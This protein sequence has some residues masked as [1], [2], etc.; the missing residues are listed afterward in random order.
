MKIKEKA[1][2][3]KVLGCFFGLVV[4]S[5]NAGARG[6]KKEEGRYFGGGHI[7]ARSATHAPA[8][9]PKLAAQASSSKIRRSQIFYARNSVCFAHA[10]DA[11]AQ[12]TMWRFGDET[13]ELKGRRDPLL[14]SVG[15]R[16]L[17]KKRPARRGAPSRGG[18]RWWG[19]VD[20]AVARSSEACAWRGGLGAG[21]HAGR[22]R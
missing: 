17:K 19:A 7:R 15:G 1:V 16:I 13:A 10:G 12:K 14:P 4:C 9:G 8:A 6:V 21:M 18:A 20:S 5:K 22:A 2:G 11:S 3:S